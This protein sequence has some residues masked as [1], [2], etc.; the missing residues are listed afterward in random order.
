MRILIVHSVPLNGGDEALLRATVESLQ[1]RWSDVEIVVACRAVE[2]CRER[3][4][5]MTLGPD[6]EC[7]S[8]VREGVF[9]KPVGSARRILRPL[10]AGGAALHWLDRVTATEEQKEVLRRYR[11]SDIILSS[12]GGFFHDHYPVEERLRGLEAALDMGKPVVLFAQSIGP[13]WKETTR[14]RIPEVFNR[15]SRICVR[16]SRSRDHLLDCGVEDSR[17]RVTADASFLWRRIAPELFR[18]RSG[19]VAR[20]AL[21]FRVW[22][23]GDTRIV[24]DTLRKA[25]LLCRHLLSEASRELLFVSTCQGIPGYVD[26]SEMALRIVEGIPD[27]LRERCV[28]DRERYSPRDLIRLL[29]SCDAFLGMRLHGCLLA[30]LGGTPAMGI[31]YEAKTEEIFRQLGF[32]SFQVGFEESGD[33]WIRC[34]ER[35]LGRASEIQAVLADRLDRLCSAADRNLDAVSECLYGGT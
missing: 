4:P 22:P 18:L 30:M 2:Q 13:F 29:G 9:R 5:D 32:D 3:L 31:G 26:D 12:P 7:A 6:L 21:C 34:T 1:A 16:D 14:R 11:E 24:E 15:V 35:F 10:G 27:D 25:V 28:V 19:P 8:G 17:I 33:D 20:A 23:P